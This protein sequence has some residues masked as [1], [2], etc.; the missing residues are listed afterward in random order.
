MTIK[1]RI[2]SQI[3]RDSAK[4]SVAEDVDRLKHPYAGAAIEGVPRRDMPSH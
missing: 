3:E 1:A 2:E 4:T